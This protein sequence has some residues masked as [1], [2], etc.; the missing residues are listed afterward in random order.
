MKINSSH[1]KVFA[2]LEA[3][4][5][6]NKIDQNSIRII[7]NQFTEMGAMS[8]TWIQVNGLGTAVFDYHKYNKLVRK[9][10]GI[11]SNEVIKE[12]EQE[13]LEIMLKELDNDN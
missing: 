9:N 1:I 7:L 13:K 2:M 6:K 12:R 8:K 3:Q 5:G 10:I 11:D 4:R